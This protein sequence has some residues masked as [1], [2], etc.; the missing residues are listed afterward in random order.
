MS[1]IFGAL[2][3]NNTDR[4]FNAT[5]GQEAILSAIVDYLARRDAQVDMLISIFVP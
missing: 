2:N 4:V 3:L 1:T 5:V